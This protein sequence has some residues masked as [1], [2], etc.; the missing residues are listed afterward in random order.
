MVLLE[1]FG[2]TCE[3]HFE[4]LNFYHILVPSISFSYSFIV[5]YANVLFWLDRNLFNV[6]FFFFNASSSNYFLFLIDTLDLQPLIFWSFTAEIQYLNACV[7]PAWL[8]YKQ[9]YSI[10]KLESKGCLFKVYVASTHMSGWH[11]DEVFPDL[12]I[13]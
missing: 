1:S 12:L 7:R 13:F 6:L 8:K 9:I 3:A 11:E 2:P 10:N 4:L 5:C